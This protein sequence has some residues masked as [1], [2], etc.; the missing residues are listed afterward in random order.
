MRLLCLGFDPSCDNVTCADFGSSLSCLDYD[1]VVWAPETTF[2]EYPSAGQYQG[3]PRLTEAASVALKD[4]IVRRGVEF[5]EMLK[6]GRPVVVVLC[7]PEVVYVDTG[8]RKYS[9][10]GRNQSTTVVVTEV[11]LLDAA[12][13]RLSL[14][15]GTGTNMAYR[16]GGSDLAGFWRKIKD[17]AYY[18]AYFREAPGQPFLFVTGTDRAVATLVRYATGG[19]LLLCPAMS[20]LSDLKELSEE[21]EFCEEAAERRILRREY[22]TQLD[23]ASRFIEAVV[24]VLVALRRELGD[25]S[26]PGWASAVLVSGEQAQRELLTEKQR[27]LEDAQRAVSEQDK[28]IASL[29]RR[30]LLF[31]GTGRALELVVRE[32]LEALGFKVEEPAAGR[33]DW[34]ARAAEGTAVVEVKGV[35][36]S[37]AERHAAQLEKWVSGYYAVDEEPAKGVLIVNAFRDLPLADRAGEAFPEQ[38]IPYST[39]RGHCLMT[40][41]QL[42]GMWDAVD[43]DASRAEGLRQLLLTTVGRLSAFDDW[44]EFLGTVEDSIASDDVGDA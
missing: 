39:A 6:L 9:G 41:S 29:E 15:A 33:D 3:R 4:T 44:Q 22:K 12:P 2:N 7:E 24:E 21:L 43:R 18:R 25:F 34:I 31:T 37:S 10:T 32:A 30:K 14:E 5:K 28:R 11:N 17:S 19:S 8:N 23:Q 1:A 40:S 26:L 16:D 38:M 20:F 35:A 13:E 36:G 27:T 42:L